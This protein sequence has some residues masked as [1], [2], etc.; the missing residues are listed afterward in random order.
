MPIT[1]DY[2]LHSSYSGDSDSP[3]EEMVL[4][5]IT[6][7]LTHICFTEHNDFDYPY[8]PDETEGMFLLNPD[9]YL[10][11]LLR[12]REIYRDKINIAFG[13]ELGLQKQCL[14]QN[15]IFAK[16][17]EYDFIIASSHVLNGIDP[18]YG[19]YFENRNTK[20][21][22]REFFSSILD[23]LKSFPNFDICGHLDYIVRYAPSK[24][25]YDFKDYLDIFDELFLYLI[26]NEKGIECN[27][28][29]YRSVLNTTNPCLGLLKRY[30]ELGGEI[31]TIGSDAHKPSDIASNYSDAEAILKEAGF[32]YYCIYENRLPEFKKL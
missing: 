15:V 21:A 23:N 14:R 26:E 28:G 6:K 2:H 12:I 5:A 3:M 29:G 22:N 25:A 30:H 20:E 17:H 31:I 8:A 18:Y 1:A 32:K 10:Y 16:Q 19:K 13:L 9:A 24:E 27:T 7:G 11:E 4:S